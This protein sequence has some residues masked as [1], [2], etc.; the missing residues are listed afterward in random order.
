ML[1]LVMLET[2]I[3]H[4][5]I[6]WEKISSVYCFKDTFCSDWMNYYFIG[7]AQTLSE[8]T[9]EQIILFYV[10]HLQ[11]KNYAQED[12]KERSWDCSIC[13]IV[14]FIFWLILL[15]FGGNMGY[16]GIWMLFTLQTPPPFPHVYPYM[17]LRKYPWIFQLLKIFYLFLPF[18]SIFNK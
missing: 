10:I 2:Q 4:N 6:L 16:A 9:F 7:H 12:W 18:I 15:R 14:F 13:G 17:K 1:T 8:F 3:N 5:Y 11:A